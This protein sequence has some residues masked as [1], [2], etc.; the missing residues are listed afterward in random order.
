MN[1]EAPS[2]QRNPKGT[3]SPAAKKVA[4]LTQSTLKEPTPQHKSGRWGSKVMY[5]CFIITPGYAGTSLYPLPLD[6]I[7][8]TTLLTSVCNI[9]QGCY[10]KKAKP[11]TIHRSRI[12]LLILLS[13]IVNQA[14]DPI[15]GCQTLER[16][17]SF[18][19]RFCRAVI[20]GRVQGH[21]ASAGPHPLACTFSPQPF[22]FSQAMKLSLHKRLL[23]KPPVSRL[24][25]QMYSRWWKPY[26][27]IEKSRPDSKPGK[28]HSYL[29]I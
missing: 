1:N 18:A 25:C 13:H 3:G 17:F 16:S 28:S 6:W 8:P 10:S 27:E 7:T 22:V 23:I 21:E 5:F 29:L 26:R 2:S 20:S 19:A 14:N 12:S 24:S 9:L 11:Q 15:T 4:S